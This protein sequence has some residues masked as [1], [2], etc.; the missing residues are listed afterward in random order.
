MSTKL[1]QIIIIDDSNL[2]NATKKEYGYRLKQFFHDRAIKSYEELID[3][4]PKLAEILT[5]QEG[6][7]E[8]SYL[9]RLE[10]ERQQCE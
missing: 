2:A 6:D 4:N 7:T 8:Q 5:F 1:R 3:T 10:L 9:L